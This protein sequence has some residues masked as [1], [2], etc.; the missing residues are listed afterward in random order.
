M[1]VIVGTGP[2]GFDRLIRGVDAIAPAFEEEIRAQIGRGE[3]VPENVEWFRF[4]SEDEIHDLYRSASVVIAH[5][6]AGTLLTALSY[7]KPIVVLPRTEHRGEHNDDHQMELATALRDR[8]GVH[9]ISDTDELE[10]AIRRAQSHD[11]APVERDRSLVRFLES[12]LGD[13]DP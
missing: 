3:Y 2:D 5:A 13:L 11:G 4:V 6:G 1:C 7:G 12:H 10:P 8:P 9:P